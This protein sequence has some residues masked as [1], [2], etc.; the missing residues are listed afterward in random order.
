MNSINRDVLK[1]WM[2][3]AFYAGAMQ[4]SAAERGQDF[5]LFDAWF[6]QWERENENQ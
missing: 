3:D 1:Q 6:D 2:T 5:V 4:E